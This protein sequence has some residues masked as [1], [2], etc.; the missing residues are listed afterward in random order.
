MSL[1]WR[2]CPSVKH[3][4]NNGKKRT[5]IIFISIFVSPQSFSLPPLCSDPLSLGYRRVILSFLAFFEILP[6]MG[7]FVISFI[8]SR[9]P[10]VLAFTTFDVVCIDQAGLGKVSMS[11]RWMMDNIP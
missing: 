7:R 10:G 9:S 3:S 5:R 2:I 6:N 11:Q 8:V 4:N 1:I